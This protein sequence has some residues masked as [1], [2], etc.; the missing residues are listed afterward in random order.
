MHNGPRLL[1][2]YQNALSTVFDRRNISFSRW[3][4]QRKKGERV[5]LV[6]KLSRNSQNH[7]I[8]SQSSR[9]YHGLLR[10]NW[11][12]DRIC[13]DEEKVGDFVRCFQDCESRQLSISV[14]YHIE[15]NNDSPHDREL[16]TT[17][18]STQTQTAWEHEKR[19]I[20]CVSFDV[21]KTKGFFFLV[22]KSKR[23]PSTQRKGFGN[24]GQRY[25]KD[26][27]RSNNAD[28]PRDNTTHSL[29]PH[30]PAPAPAAT[31]HVHRQLPGVHRLLSAAKSARSPPPEAPVAEDLVR[32]P[33]PASGSKTHPREPAEDISG[34]PKPAM[35]QRE[36]IDFVLVVFG[37]NWLEF[38]IL[39]VHGSWLEMKM[40]GNGVL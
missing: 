35:V 30:P 4:Y 39:K 27:I 33:V 16:R 9:G 21:S 6:W 7:D 2:Q 28:E 26:L 14:G 20:I 13:G 1:T 15:G 37:L 19:N 24:P 40:V 11:Q 34:N 23:K 12:W 29:R 5:F 31:S 22:G 36:W 38:H 32:E 3:I 8:H 10:F 25:I 17:V 18:Q